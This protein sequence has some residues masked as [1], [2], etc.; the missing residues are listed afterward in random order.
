[1]TV[2]PSVL[3][4]IPFM[5]SE[6]DPQNPEFAR[7]VAKSQ[8]ESSRLGDKRSKAMMDESDKRVE[9]SAET[10]AVI[11]GNDLGKRQSIDLSD[12]EKQM[13]LSELG[14]DPRLYGNPDITSA[15]TYAEAERFSAASKE[16]TGFLDSDPVAYSE[17]LA[18]LDSKIKNRSQE[19]EKATRKYSSTQKQLKEFEEEQRLEQY[20]FE[21]EAA[22]DIEKLQQEKYEAALSEEKAVREISKVTQEKFNDLT[23]QTLKAFKNEKP[24][25]A[26]GTFGDL[27]GFF[28]DNDDFSAKKTASTVFWLAGTFLNTFLSIGTEGKIPNYFMTAF[29]KAVDS[30]FKAKRMEASQMATFR[31]EKRQA[32]Q[33]SLNAV[34]SRFDSTVDQM[35]VYRG[36]MLRRFGAAVDQIAAKP[37]LAQF[38]TNPKYQAALS[39]FKKDIKYEEQLTNYKLASALKD[40][41]IKEVGQRTATLSAASAAQQREHGMK[42]MRLEMSKALAAPKEKKIAELTTADKE[43]YTSSDRAMSNLQ[44][45]LAIVDILERESGDTGRSIDRIVADF[46]AKKYFPFSIADRLQQNGRLLARQY[47]RT[48]DK[49]NLAES[50]QQFTEDVMGFL[51]RNNLSQIRAVLKKFEMDVVGQTMT[52]YLLTSETNKP[53]LLPWMSTIGI[54]DPSKLFKDVQENNLNFEESMFYDNRLRKMALERRLMSAENKAQASGSLFFG[55]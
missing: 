28:D 38:A 19:L 3:S 44:E 23:E 49:G 4:S 40:Q 14:I 31:A 30:D 48:L 7:Y 15:S 22:Q 46:D 1:M 18:G 55:D 6:P 36:A 43:F 2:V 42:L 37:E 25:A 32:R 10:N 21:L 53:I 5:S 16:L 24:P 8:M 41:A 9:K 12:D 29:F 17:K 51:A 50:E 26:P 11:A 20:T 54:Q 35:N 13:S 33:D 39:V 47:A 45:A 52:R 34:I 27:I